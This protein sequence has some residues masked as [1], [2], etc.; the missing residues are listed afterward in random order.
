M[1]SLAQYTVHDLPYPAFGVVAPVPKPEANVG[2][3]RSQ[4]FNLRIPLLHR[5]E[6]VPFEPHVSILEEHLDGI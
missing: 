1:L 5:N 6:I 2:D 3:L 4:G